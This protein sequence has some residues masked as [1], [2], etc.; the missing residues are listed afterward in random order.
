MRTTTKV[1]PR[2]P[3]E[4]Q[5]S[6]TGSSGR[7]LTVLCLIH[8][9]PR[10]NGRDKEMCCPVFGSGSQQDSRGLGD[11]GERSAVPA[12]GVPES[13]L[14]QDGAAPDRGGSHGL[15]HA[16]GRDGPQQHLHA[17]C[18]QPSGPVNSVLSSD[19]VSYVSWFQF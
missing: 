6:S 11:Q 10:A 18:F 2:A 9:R 7:C 4:M 8:W 17:F 13:R 14:G 16:Q 1:S 19:T 12:C 15:R 3:G 5:A